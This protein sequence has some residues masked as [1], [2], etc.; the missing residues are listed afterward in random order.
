MAEVNINLEACFVK[1]CGCRGTSITPG[2]SI[3]G[4]RDG[5]RVVL[6]PPFGLVCDVCHEPWE[7]HIVLPDGSTMLAN[8]VELSSEG[9][10]WA[11][12]TQN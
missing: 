7:L 6:S 9:V 1:A 8:E 10:E 2:L 5:S 3:R 4:H 11:K 12:N